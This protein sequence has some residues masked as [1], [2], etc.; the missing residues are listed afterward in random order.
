M[1]IWQINGDTKN[2]KVA[3]LTDSLIIIFC[4]M[5]KTELQSFLTN[6]M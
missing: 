1:E 3:I 6:K 4:K 5:T 2:D